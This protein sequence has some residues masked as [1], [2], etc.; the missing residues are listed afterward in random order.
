MKC[1]EF[2]NE[3]E[4]QG[5]LS[6]TAKLHLEE[7][8]KCQSFSFQQ[9]LV[10]EML[11][12]LGRVEVPKDFD[13]RVKARIAEARAGSHSRE[14]RFF[15]ALRYVLPLGFAVVLLSFVALSGLYFVD[16]QTGGPVITLEE[17]TVPEK[18]P[19]SLPGTA[20]GEAELAEQNG[21]SEVVA[22][23]TKGP[24]AAP[25]PRGTEQ[26]ERK[27]VAAEN[28]TVVG[29]SRDSVEKA[30]QVIRPEPENTGGGSRDLA[31][32]KERKVLTPQ[33]FE[34]N[35]KPKLPPNPNPVKAVEVIE[36][37]EVIGIKAVRENGSFKVVSVR[38][39]SL[40]DRSDVRSSDLIEAINGKKLS[41]EPIR[42]KL[43]SIK[44][45]TV[46]RDGQKRKIALRPN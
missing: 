18:S 27:E 45:I 21:R 23:P 11:G 29:G 5:A 32:K 39:N 15:P 7:C 35:R 33:G 17:P 30:P 14:N 42:G 20:P 43:I 36:I 31:S 6:E 34:A 37:L 26:A 16:T 22:G 10:W 9:N 24:V 40:A 3:F 25:A 28:K 1:I 12:G 4:E 41:G 19:S 38:K 44:T 8:A 46:V 2:Q 13:F